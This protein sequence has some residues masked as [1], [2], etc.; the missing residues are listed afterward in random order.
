MSQI[1]NFDFLHFNQNKNIKKHIKEEI[2]NYSDKIKKTNDKG[3]VQERNIV[4]TNKAI[5]NFNGTTFRRRIP[6]KSLIAITVSSICDE[7]IVHFADDEYDYLYSSPKKKKIIEII[8]NNFENESESDFELFVLPNVLKDYITTKK[9]KKNNKQFS[10]KPTTGKMDVHEYIFGTKRETIPL[11]NRD[12]IFNENTT[13]Y[14]NTNVDISSFEIIKTI[15]RGAYGKILLAEYKKSNNLYAIKVIRKDQIISED[16][17]DNILLEKQILSCSKNEFILNLSF[18]FQTKERLYFVTPYM[19]GGDLYNL[20]KKKIHLD[21]KTVKNCAAQIAIALEYLH[22]QGIIYRDLKPENILIGDDGYI[23]LCDFGASVHTFKKNKEYVFSGSPIYASPEIVNYQGHSILS[24]WWSFGILIYELLYGIT[25]FYN[26]NKNKM[27]ELINNGEIFFPEN[28]QIDDFFIKYSVSNEAK[29]LILKLLTKEDVRLGKRGF[30][31]IMN[32][33]FFDEV[34]FD[35]IRNKK[36]NSI[37]KPV[38]QNK[39]DLS[40]FSEE[41]L[42]MDINESPVE[43]WIKNYDDF[44]EEFNTVE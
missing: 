27:F 37:L 44:F 30:N 2:I 20:L 1:D 29:D 34:N 18:F 19:P 17:V 3:K 35:Y 16:I 40:N 32:H 13:Q 42:E 39:K 41:F 28:N 4:L 24:D 23:K 7:F 33:K 11:V 6:L 38:L 5:Y 25:P 9:D 8:S 14:L 22:S 21:E 15:G 26:Q 31:E 10:K 36:Y 12:T 43:E